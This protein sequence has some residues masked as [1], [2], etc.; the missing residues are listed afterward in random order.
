MVKFV[1]TAFLV[2][3]MA[4]SDSAEK[5]ISSLSTTTTASPSK[6]AADANSTTSTT[7]SS[8]NG[9]G[10]NEGLTE[11]QPDFKDL[12]E[13]E[14]TAEGGNDYGEHNHEKEEIA[15]WEK[16]LKDNLTSEAPASRRLKG[17]A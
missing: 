9:R 12:W 15:A 6:V 8:P 5:I 2:A 14:A 17:E 10:Q 4:S 7:T 11:E 3:A 16:S 1:M 13:A